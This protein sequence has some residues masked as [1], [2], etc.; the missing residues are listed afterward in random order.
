MVT[1]I[2]IICITVFIVSA[3]RGNRKKPATASLTKPIHPAIYSS[4]NKLDISDRKL[5]ISEQ[6]MNRHTRI[7]SVLFIINSI[8]CCQEKYPSKQD[9]KNL[10]YAINAVL[11]HKPQYRDIQTAIKFCQIEYARGNCDHKLTKQDLFIIRNI[12]QLIA[13]NQ[14]PVNIPNAMHNK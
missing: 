11:E 10:D 5:R 2:L 13:N 3:I 9:W 4:K 1:I 6:R 7:W 8:R 14:L 12:R